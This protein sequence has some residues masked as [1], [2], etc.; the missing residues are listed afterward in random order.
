MS[1][2]I[3]DM[4][5]RSKEERTLVRNVIDQH[6]V[7]TRELVDKV[8]Y[9]ILKYLNEK[10]TRECSRTEIARK[11]L[12]WGFVSGKNSYGQAYYRIKR[13]TEFGLIKPVRIEPAD[14]TNPKGGGRR[15]EI[16]TLNI[17]SSACTFILKNIVEYLKNQ[18]LLFER[19][20]TE[21]DEV[22]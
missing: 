21:L 18:V 6:L 4:S 19:G 7:K 17:S 11:L 22:M 12:D 10:R 8:Y 9:Y 1:E 13:L 20:K 16:F 2:L 14:T 15:K 5:F 3:R